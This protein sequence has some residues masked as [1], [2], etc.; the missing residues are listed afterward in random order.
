MMFKSQKKPEI[1]TWYLLPQY[2]P[3]S[4]VMHFCSYEQDWF[5]F[6]RKISQRFDFITGWRYIQTLWLL[7]FVLSLLIWFRG[8]PVW[9][10]RMVVNLSL[11]FYRCV[12]EGGVDYGVITTLRGWDGGR[13]P[14]WSH[15]AATL[16]S[17][18]KAG[19]C[20]AHLLSPFPPSFLH[21]VIYGKTRLQGSRLPWLLDW[22]IDLWRLWEGLVLATLVDWVWSRV[23]GVG[24]HEGKG[25]SLNLYVHLYIWRRESIEFLRVSRRFRGP[26]KVKSHAREELA[27][28]SWGLGLAPDLDFCSQL[29]WKPGSSSEQWKR[30]RDLQGPFPGLLERF[31]ILYFNWLT[32]LC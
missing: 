28:S 3:L 16:V 26:A 7:E 29:F 12:S 9:P 19:T 15:W 6:W 18:A 25:G 21:H 30:L 4:W 14:P 13:H 11:Q 31:L 1:W 24:V 23:S 27:A 10:T 20:Q 8:A 2:F 32:T 22:E 5:F 17:E